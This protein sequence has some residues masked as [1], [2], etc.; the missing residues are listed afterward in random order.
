M[1]QRKTNVVAVTIAI[2]VATFM[3]AIEGT[4]VST[5]LPTIVGDLHGVSLMNWVFSI[6]LLTNAMMTPIYGKLTDLVGRKPVMQAGLIIFIIGSMMSG[7]SNSMPVLIFWRAI[8]GIGAG[9]LMPV[10]MTIIADI[11]SFERRAKVL[12]FN[13]SAWGIASVLAPLIG[14]L[15]VDKLSWHWIFFINVPVGLITLFLFQ[16]YLREPK[17]HNDVKIDYLGSWWLMLFLLC[18]MLSFQLLGN[19]TISWTAVI[20]AWVI[21]ALSLWLFIRRESRTD[22]PVIS[23]DLFKNR[24]FVIQNAVAALVSGFLM[25]VEVYIPTWTQGILGVP[26]SLAGF[27]VTPSSLMWIVGSFVTGR[28]LAKWA[29]R[30]ILYLSLAFILVTSI[31]LAW[32]PVTTAFPWF[33]LITAIGGIGFGITITA[34]TVTSQH[35]VPA[36]NVGVA[37]SFNTLSRTIGQTLMISIFGIALNVGMNQGIQQHPATNM[38]ML[39]KLINPQTATELPQHLLPTLH[40]ILYTGL[41]WVYLIGLGLV[42]LALLVNSLDRGVQKTAAEH[43]ADLNHNH[44]EL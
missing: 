29:P 4:I 7:L 25:A 37:T 8:Q 15:I 33:F 41:H 38:A 14:G 2:Y 27:A 22:E 24:T 19:A 40:R 10:S 28:L 20:A 32:L 30:R 35:L 17:R 13:S 42:I 39:N 21:S 43:A 11:Y 36:K 9:A 34:T 44:G 31:C 23:M 26:A 18:L 3:S 16:F 1:Q 5:A 6:Y 12:G